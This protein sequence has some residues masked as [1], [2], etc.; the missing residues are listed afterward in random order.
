MNIHFTHTDTANAYIEYLT[1]IL[2]P[3]IYDG[4]KSIYDDC[5]II[6][7]GNGNNIVIFQNAL[8][9]ISKWEEQTKHDEYNRLSTQ[10]QTNKL[11]KITKAIIKSK[12]RVLLGGKSLNDNLKT[13]LDEN[14]LPVKFIHEIYLEIARKLYMTPH[15]MSCDVNSFERQKN[16][17][18]ILSMIETSIHKAIY[19]LIPI[20]DIAE[21]YLINDETNENEIFDTTIRNTIDNLSQII[22]D[23][24]KVSVSS[25]FKNLEKTF[26]N[27]REQNVRSE[28]SELSD[29]ESY[30]SNKIQDGGANMSIVSEL[31][32]ASKLMNNITTNQYGGDG[33]GSDKSEKSD[34]SDSFKSDNSKIIRLDGDD[35][36]VGGDGYIYGSEKSEKSY[37]GHDEY[38]DDVDTSYDMK[39][40]QSGGVQSLNQTFVPLPNN[41]VV[42]PNPPIPNTPVLSHLQPTLPSNISSGL[43]PVNAHNVTSIIT[44]PVNSQP[45][46]SHPNVQPPISQPNVLPPISQPNVLPPISQPN[47]QPPQLGG[48]YT[49]QSKP[50]INNSISQKPQL[51]Q[52]GGYNSI[53]E[54]G[55]VSVR[56]SDFLSD[57][58]AADD[59][60]RRIKLRLDGGGIGNSISSLREQRYKRSRNRFRNNNVASKFTFFDD[61]GVSEHD[62]M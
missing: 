4:I 57:S 29:C 11:Q 5:K 31:P 23:N 17:N 14:D 6:T 54:I 24:V 12:I 8:K 22:R 9:A 46:I 28:G 34:R 16:I 61:H 58:D 21:E 35:V 36:H 2:T 50:Y 42:N 32:E 52:S 39:H 49:E 3:H 30:T 62:N 25:E 56:R 44:P 53:E 47:V 27:I 18:I 26:G 13:L 7:K 38:I 19:K 43:V 51:M 37:D 55:A 33:Y 40:N 41:T 59:D 48:D 15:L 60:T 1:S 10:L 45:P 20:D